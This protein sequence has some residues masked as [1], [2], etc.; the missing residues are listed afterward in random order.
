MP[1]RHM[2]P[3]SLQLRCQVRHWHH[4]LSVVV[5]VV[6]THKVHTSSSLS[7]FELVGWPI[8]R[9]QYPIHLI[10]IHGMLVDGSI[11]LCLCYR[12]KDWL[13]LVCEVGIQVLDPH[14]LGR[15]PTL[16]LTLIDH[17]RLVLILQFECVQLIDK[18]INIRSPI[19][20]IH[21]SRQYQWFLSHIIIALPLLRHG[22]YGIRQQRCSSYMSFA[23][24]LVVHEACFYHFARSL[25]HLDEHFHHLCVAITDALLLNIVG[26]ALKVG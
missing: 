8:P 16:S 18:L 13:A 12:S 7:G 9:L 26:Y 17:L 11:A 3:V 24:I 5:V 10:L 4:S 25:F 21:F 20:I 14:G 23:T 2:I 6:L 1:I 22:P 19:L 15:L